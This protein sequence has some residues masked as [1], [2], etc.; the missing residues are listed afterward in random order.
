[1]KI[2]SIIAMALTIPCLYKNDMD[3]IRAHC[4]CSL[5]KLYLRKQ[6]SNIRMAMS[7]LWRGLRNI[8]GFILDG[9]SN[10]QG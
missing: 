10:Q 8:H 4:P 9:K 2:R 6:V 5:L 7:F 3:L 1:M